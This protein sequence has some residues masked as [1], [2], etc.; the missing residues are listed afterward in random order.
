MFDDL[1][2][3]DKL[4]KKREIFLSNVLILELHFLVRCSILA[5]N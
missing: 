4:S 2:Q 1:F 3:E 5:T